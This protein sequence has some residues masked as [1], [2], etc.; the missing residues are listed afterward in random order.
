MYAEQVAIGF[1]SIDVEIRMKMCVNLHIPHVNSNRDDD[2]VDHNDKIVS[3]ETFNALLLFFKCYYV[4]DD[5][6]FP[7]TTI[8]T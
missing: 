3:F 8:R 4:M 7:Q 5:Y 1:R 2:V 6:P